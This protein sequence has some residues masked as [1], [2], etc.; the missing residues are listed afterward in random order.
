MHN[1]FLKSDLTLCMKYKKQKIQILKFFNFIIAKVTKYIFR[2]FLNNAFFWV[3][4]FKNL[5][6][7]HSVRGLCK[8]KRLYIG[9]CLNFMKSEVGPT[10]KFLK[11]EGE[12][13]WPFLF[14]HH[15]SLRMNFCE[16]RTRLQKLAQMYSHKGFLN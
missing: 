7:A 13:G 14:F 16:R 15:F 4:F 12:P 9:F 3:P 1:I 5:I 6:F 8:L 11:I 2:F 10:S